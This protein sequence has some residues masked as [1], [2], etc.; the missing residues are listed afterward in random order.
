MLKNPKSYFERLKALSTGKR[1][2]A[3]S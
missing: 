2:Q 1:F 3:A